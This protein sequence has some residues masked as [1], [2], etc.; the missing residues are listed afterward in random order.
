MPHGLDCNKSIRLT[1]VPHPQVF[2]YGEQGR[3]IYGDRELVSDEYITT[4]SSRFHR[5]SLSHLKDGIY[6]ATSI[7]G[8]RIFETNFK[9][10]NNEVVDIISNIIRNENQK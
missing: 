6:K 1:S 4:P 2:V 5:F 7:F 3:L 10:E 9:I 8:S